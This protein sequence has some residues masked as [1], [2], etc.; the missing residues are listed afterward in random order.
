MSAAENAGSSSKR[1]L[2]VV[3]VGAG[4]GGIAAA[5]ELRGH[6]ITNIRIVANW[7]GYMREYLQQTAA[8][9]ASE[10]AFLP[11]PDRAQLTRA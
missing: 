11:L 3:I 2:E 9:D 10:Y 7:P 5:V 8:L 4:F 1:S 6:G